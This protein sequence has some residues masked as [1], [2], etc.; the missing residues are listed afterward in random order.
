MMVVKLEQG[1]GGTVTIL[2]RHAGVVHSVICQ[3][4]IIR[5]L[6]G[7]WLL[8][9]FGMGFTYSVCPPKSEYVVRLRL[10]LYFFIIMGVLLISMNKVK[11]ELKILSERFHK[12]TV[13]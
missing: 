4:I 12:S 3:E 11:D 10:S 6:N 2:A 13:S 7:S 8:V 5:A 9:N 1:S